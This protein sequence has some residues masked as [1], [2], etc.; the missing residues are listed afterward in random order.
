MGGK[1][2]ETA[3]NPQRAGIES[4]VARVLEHLERNGKSSFVSSPSLP[5]LPPRRIEVPIEAS[6]RHVH[7]NA[8]ALERL[9]GRDPILRKKRDLSQPGEFLAEQRVKLVTPKG[10]IPN[11]AILGPL[12]P[13][14][15][16]EISRTDCRLLGVTPPLN[17]SGDLKD[18]SDVFIVGTDGMI[19]AKG[20][21]IIARAHVH[22]RAADAEA[23][24]L[25]NGGRVGVEIDSKRPT[26][27]KNVIVRVSDNFS[28]AV[29][30]DFDEANACM[31]DEESRAY[32]LCGESKASGEP[33]I[34]RIHIANTHRQSE[35][36]CEEKVVTEAVAR[37]LI[38]ACKGNSVLV[39]R[40]TILTPSAQD[41]FLTAKKTVERAV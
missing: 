14:V 29:H 12:R 15:Q 41:V 17:V 1:P 25:A 35:I 3:I 38:A 5:F 2:V 31:L 23:C 8:E 18:A 7:L 37:R 28:P 27:F 26:T 40:G 20:S 30:I 19:E 16:V 9:F 6:A 21:M 39:K 34:D 13:D 22:L 33:H 10:E 32:L 4:I 24:G 11:V 36:C